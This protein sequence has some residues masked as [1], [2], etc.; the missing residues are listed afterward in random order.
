MSPSSSAAAAYHAAR[1]ENAPPLKLVQMMYEGALRFLEQAEGALA[2][3]DGVRFQERCM[4]AQAV[5]AELRM[6]LDAAQAPE[7]AANL[8]SLYLFAESQI[9]AAM[10][11][12][13]AEGL[14][15]AREVLTTLLDGWKRLELKA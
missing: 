15:P 4:R 12:D 9:R 7:L 3:G 6:S 8:N 11:S 10:L 5:V 1:F 2:A 14:G 13:T